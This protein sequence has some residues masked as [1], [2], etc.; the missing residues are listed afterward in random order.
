MGSGPDQT[1]PDQAGYREEAVSPRALLAAIRRE[2]D[3]VAQAE[4]ANA[5]VTRME[6]AS[7]RIAY[8]YCQSLMLDRRTWLPDIQ[9][10]VRI[11]AH[12]VL[13]DYATGRLLTVEPWSDLLAMRARDTVARFVNS[14][15]THTGKCRFCGREATD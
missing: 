3:P 9:E 11:A 5:F 4:L 13:A 14:P 15:D 8:R 1:R 12:G 6:P 10:C 2:T 7:K